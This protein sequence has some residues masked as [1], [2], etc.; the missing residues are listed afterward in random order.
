MA[1]PITFNILIAPTGQLT[2]NGQL[3]ESMFERRSR[4]G[5]EYPMWYLNSDLVIRFKLSD[6]KGF[7]AVVADDPSTI[8]W[9]K[10][11]FGGERFTA[12]MDIDELWEHASQLPEADKRRDI[13]IKK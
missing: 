7:E 13:S 9:L 2:G 12:I 6:K 3:R 1:D 8:T 5:N 4:K 11:R 10:L